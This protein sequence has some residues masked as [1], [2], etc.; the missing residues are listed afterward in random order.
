MYISPKVEEFMLLCGSCNRAKSWSCEHCQNWTADHLIKVCQACYW[1][2]PDNYA[3]IALELVRRL[4]V[5]WKGG[6]VPE[7]DRLVELSKHSKKK[8]PSFVKNLLKKS[9]RGDGKV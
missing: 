6:E 8:L 9:I 3:H 5:V 4:D 2:T 1:A 7:Y